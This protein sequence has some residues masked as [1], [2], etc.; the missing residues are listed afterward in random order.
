MG[1]WWVEVSLGKIKFENRPKI[2]LM[3]F[4]ELDVN[5]YDLNVLS[6]SVMGFKKSLY[7][8]RMVCALSSF[9]WIFLL[10]KAPNAE[11]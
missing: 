1:G 11:L 5:H 3:I 4:G 7:R 6:L 9:S 10:C 2:L 8:G